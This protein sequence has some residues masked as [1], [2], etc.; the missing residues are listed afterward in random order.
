MTSRHD[1]GSPGRQIPVAF[2]RRLAI[3][4]RGSILP[5]DLLLAHLP[6]LGVRSRSFHTQRIDRNEPI[7]SEPWPAFLT[8][9]APESTVVRQSAE[10]VADVLGNT[11]DVSRQSYIAPVVIE[12]FL[13]GSL[14]VSRPR[15]GEPGQGEGSL[16]D[17]REELALVHF[18]ERSGSLDDMQRPG[19]R[20]VTRRGS[21]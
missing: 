15:R 21:R 16:V 5:P 17:R 1:T 2:L 3:S 7:R 12:A 14:P 13:A 10:T 19:A 4:G 11:P 18:L 6:S 9:G 8:S 20:C